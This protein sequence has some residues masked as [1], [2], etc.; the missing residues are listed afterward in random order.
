MYDIIKCPAP[1]EAGSGHYFSF[2]ESRG[3][4]TEAENLRAAALL[5]GKKTLIMLRDHAFDEGAIRLIAEKK[6]ACFLI[7]LGRLIRMR[8]VPRAIAISKLRNFLRICVKYGAFYTFATFA[9]NES[10]LRSRQELE[11]II[12]LLGL[13]RGQARFALKM[14]P[15]YL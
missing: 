5:R 6:S 2:N 8:G 14:L 4:I 7:D 1:P 9:E 15:H 10:E 12:C 11:S 13:N 3:R